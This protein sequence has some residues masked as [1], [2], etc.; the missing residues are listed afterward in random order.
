MIIFNNT[1]KRLSPI[2]K[3]YLIICASVY[4]FLTF[5]WRLFYMATKTMQ[6]FAAKSYLF[7]LPILV[8]G[9]AYNV[10]KIYNK[11]KFE[12]E[13]VAF[14]EKV[15][16]SEIILQP[17]SKEAIE[18]IDLECNYSSPNINL[19]S[20]ENNYSVDITIINKSKENILFKSGG[21]KYTYNVRPRLW[22]SNLKK[23]LRDGLK[24]GLRDLIGLAVVKPNSSFTSSLNFEA[25]SVGQ[26]PKNARYLVFGLVQEG[27]RWAPTLNCKIELVHEEK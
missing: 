22:N 21:G 10:N 19:E 20:P 9:I 7:V 3:L 27:V 2:L 15:K 16:S 13:S 24:I 17:I 12:A 25:S 11:Y 5:L 26:V 23:P 4:Y 1:R 6:R 8:V 14:Y 18:N